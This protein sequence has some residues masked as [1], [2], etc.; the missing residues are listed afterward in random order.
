MCVGVCVV[1][2]AERCASLYGPRPVQVFDPDL[3]SAAA[4][5]RRAIVRQA[6]GKAD[7]LLQIQAIF[8]CGFGFGLLIVPFP[9]SVGTYLLLQLTELHALIVFRA[10]YKTAQD[11][12][13]SLAHVKK[14]IRQ[15]SYS[16]AIA[17]GI[18]LSLVYVMSP[19]SWS[20]GV[21]AG[22]G[23][24]A[25]YFIPFAKQSRSILYTSLGIFH[26]TLLFS[27]LAR[28]YYLGELSLENVAAPLALVLFI[29]VTTVA[30]AVNVR[31]EYFKRLGD[32]ELIEHA[33]TELK[34]ESRAKSILLAQLSHEIR[35]P[36]SG[37]LGSAELMA[38]KDMPDDQRHL[39]DIMRESGGNLVN[40]VNLL[41]RILEISAAEV[42]AIAIKRA[43]A[44]LVDI[45]AEEVALFSSRAHQAGVSL[46]MENGFCDQSR[47]I[48]D[49]RVRQCIA[50][51]IANAIDH[52]G[53]DQITVSCSEAT[54]RAITI[55][56]SD[57][58][59]GVPAHRSEL[60]FHAFGDKGLE[61]PYE[62]QGAG[63]GLALSRSIAQAMG[64]DLKL[65][66]NSG[67]GSIFELRF[68]VPAV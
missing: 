44:V 27:A 9:V 33:F 51:L 16:L 58:G 43:P 55:T 20:L 46:I 7:S 35:T 30:I 23:V 31:I 2:L 13:A 25:A 65:F 41:D 38:I 57:N 34:A 8:L 19:E 52:S 60:I 37:I 59:R 24:A 53:A 12:K 36:L 32:E 10:V 15:L 26:V 63:L 45:I 17:G 11:P 48:E 18:C 22:C 1:S 5:E 64:G 3:D 14:P 61:G 54:E 68:A 4:R 6:T 67:P 56:V 29:M 66:N 42:D 50:N 40:L 39:V 47:Q 62:G 21:L 28:P 49:V